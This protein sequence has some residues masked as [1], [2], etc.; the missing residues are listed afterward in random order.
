MNADQPIWLSTAPAAPRGDGPLAGIRFGVKDN[1][2]VT[3]LPTTA[4]CPDLADRVAERSATAVRLLVEAGAVV[5][6]K[7]NMDQFAT[8]LVGTRSPYGACHAVDSAAHIS[9]G[10]SS[11]SAIAVAGGEVALALGT[12]TAGSGRVPAAFNGLVGAKPTRG[13]VSTAGVLPACR[14]LD[15]VTTFTRTVREAR[16]ALDVLVAFDP[17]DPWSRPMPPRPP[18]GVAAEARV[19]AVPD[20]PL[21]LGREHTTAWKLALA[22]A[23]TVARLV[24]V[25]IEPF[26]AAGKLLYGGPWVA[27]RWAGFGHLLGGPSVD[28][29]VRRIVAAGRDIAGPDVFA[30]L[31]ALAALRRATEPVFAGA[32]ALLL[33]TTPVHPTLAEVAADPVGVNARLGTYTTFVN[34]L[35]L[36]AIAV[37]AGRR[38]D[39]LPFG[40]QLIGPA[41]A[42]PM[43]IDLAA[44]WCGEPATAPGVPTGHLLLAVSHSPLSAEELL[45][46]ARKHA[47]Q[48][49]VLGYVA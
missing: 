22:H 3:G 30:A 29:T 14:S 34:L 44:R 8:G 11:G 43:L 20:G 2:D 15:C 21:D 36:C 48:A 9:G 1:I 41:F 28:P 12:D 23:A 7:T 24:P 35:D 47:Q 31:D 6:G 27:E 33:P 5:A 42:D 4:A 26:L 46:R 19:L 40:V 37:P 13:L 10:S 32:D 17:A 25:D 39:G 38:A 49:E 18:A 16:A 45:N